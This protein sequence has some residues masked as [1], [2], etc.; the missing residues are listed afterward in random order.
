MV[1]PSARARDDSRSGGLRLRE[2]T[3]ARAIVRT[4]GC[5]TSV[6]LEVLR[7]LAES[8]AQIR[9]HGDFDWPGIVMVKQLVAMFDAKPWR[10]SADD[11]LDSAAP[12]G[13]LTS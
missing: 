7:R 6:I 3:R 4:S 8:G 9:Y 11:Y 1:G 5:S 2:P 10:M 12:E 13:I